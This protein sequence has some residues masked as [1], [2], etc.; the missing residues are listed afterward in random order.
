MEI[1]R[2]GFLGLFGG[3]VALPATSLL[4]SED[5]KAAEF[6]IKPTTVKPSY[7]LNGDGTIEPSYQSHG[8]TVTLKQ[9]N[10]RLFARCNWL[11]NR[12]IRHSVL[13]IR[14][15]SP[16]SSHIRTY[17]TDIEVPVKYSTLYTFQVES[18]YFNGERNSSSITLYTPKLKNEEITKRSTRRS[19]KTRKSQYD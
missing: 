14:G 12:N 15:G 9:R 2:R 6:P 3:A 5:V 11:E 16:F 13:K 19:S 1:L 8:F 7:D 10:N 18:F 4:K 17:E